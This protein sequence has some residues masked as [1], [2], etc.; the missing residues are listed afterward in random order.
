MPVIGNC[1]VAAGNKQKWVPINIELPKSS[2]ARKNWQSRHDQPPETAG[3]GQQTSSSGGKDDVANFR[4]RDD[5]HAR[6]ATARKND[7]SPRKDRKDHR[8]VVD[9][10]GRDHGRPNSASTKA[11]AAPGKKGKFTISIK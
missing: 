9:R 11:S 6:Q 10:G 5:G 7:G 8:D 2:R 3:E 4:H 1:Y